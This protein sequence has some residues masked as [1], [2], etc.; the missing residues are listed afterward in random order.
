MYD[1]HYRQ[2]LI[3]EIYKLGLVT[4]MTMAKQ[5]SQQEFNKSVQ[6]YVNVTS[7]PL[8]AKIDSY[9]DEWFAAAEN[10]IKPNP[11]IVEVRFVPTGRWYDGWETRR[12]NTDASDWVII[13]LG[14]ASANLIGCEVDT[15]FFNG[16]HAPAI[17]VDAATIQEGVDPSNVEW[18]EVIPKL[19]CGPTRQQFFLRDKLTAK[20]YTHVKLHMY[21]DGGIARFRMYGQP[22]PVF[23]EDKNL[24]I[25]MASISNGGTCVACSDEHFSSADNLLL[26]GRGIDMSD[27]WE[28]A[29]SREPSHVDW[30]L[31]KL[32]APTYVDHVV[33]D[34]AFF[35]G[36]FPQS[37]KIE[38]TTLGEG[39]I[40]TKDASWT[41][42]VP[43]TKT[44]ANHEHKYS[45][46]DSTLKANE[47]PVTHVKLTMIPDGG[48]KR[49]RVFGRRA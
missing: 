13:K 17:S 44:Q 15:T 25:D 10:L 39:E 20:A 16:N 24:V 29:R 9:S 22:V 35:F 11:P 21:P 42:I 1:L 49:F 23:P 40:D 8:G 30:A 3:K 48:I 32:G 41:E 26:P 45:T 6:Q 37:V 5:V 28:T 38:G 18:D 33:V 31:I 4:H 14:V 2:A 27:G 19:D 36:N 7:Q 46:V 47:K 34:T 43:K 12:H